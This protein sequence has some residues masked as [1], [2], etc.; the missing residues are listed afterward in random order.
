VT[1]RGFPGRL[2]QDDTYQRIAKQ[3]SSF[4]IRH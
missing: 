3:T 1:S 2:I 4:D